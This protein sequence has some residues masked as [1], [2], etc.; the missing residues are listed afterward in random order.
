ML[1]VSPVVVLPHMIDL[2]ASRAAP[3]SAR[4][5]VAT[6][7]PAPRVGLAPMTQNIDDLDD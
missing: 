2:L 6:E 7:V 5:L 1:D 3:P 4:Y